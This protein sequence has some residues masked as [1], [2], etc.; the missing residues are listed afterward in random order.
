[1]TRTY[2][3]GTMS[4]VRPGTWRLR[5]FAEDP[6]SG[7]HRQVSKT[8]HT[9][10]RPSQK[11]LDAQMAKFKGEVDKRSGSGRLATLGRVLDD[12]LAELEREGRARSTLETYRS[13]IKKWIRPALG[14]VTLEK[15]T[16]E[17]IRAFMGS[18]EGSP[19]TQRLTHAILRGALAF[20][21]ANDWMPS[22]PAS[23]V[24]PPRVAMASDTSLTPEKVG[25]LIV[26]AQAK[27]PVMGVAILLAAVT[28]LRRG[29]LCGLRW[30]D[31]DWKAETIKVERAWVPGE[32]GQHLTETKTHRRRTISVAG[33]TAK[34][35]R[36]WRAT[37]EAEWGE[38]G[39]W[40]LSEAGGKIPL[41]AKQVTEVFGRLADRVGVDAHLHDLRHFAQTQLIGA[42]VDVKTVA[43]RGGH[44]P[45]VLL[46]TYT[47]GIAERDAD[48]AITLGQ[49]VTQ[50]LPKEADVS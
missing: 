35:L 25:Q 1:M 42:G 46:E 10:T 41:R 19:R 44:T 11:Y 30:D 2:G 39:E 20:A 18:L 5:V 12:W 32:G 47:H 37:Q 26:A 50:A 7:R 36:A 4:E 29:E 40:L 45:Q 43:A 21:V 16:P 17:R 28:G 8:I 24:R 33:D 49:I 9:K 6:I 31:V 14:K 27:S 34:V 13:H 48:A 22:N 38:V 23:K 3:T 15:M